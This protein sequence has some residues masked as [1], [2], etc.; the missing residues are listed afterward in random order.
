[1]N[2]DKTVPRSIA[3]KAARLRWDIFCRIVD[4]YGDIGV[5]WRLARQLA[6]E[7][8]LAVRL[9]VD[10]AGIAQRMITGMQPSLERQVMDGVEI[11]R[12][13]D[14]F[15]DE[16]VADVVIEAF[17]CELPRN[18]LVA[19]VK[20]RPIWLN[21]EYLSAEN[22]VEEFHLRPSPQPALPLTKH[23]FFPG[24]TGQTGGLIREQG[25]I[26]QRDAF[27]NSSQAQATFW[28]KLAVVDSAALKVSLFCY[29]D[30]PIT[31]LLQ[32][33]AASSQPVLCL[34][35]DSGILPAIAKYFGA[36]PLKVGDRLSKNN[37][38][39]QPLP[40]LS[41]DDYDCLLWVCDLNFV[42]G[43]DSWVRALWAARPLIWQPYRQQQ[44]THLLKL[45]AF[46]D[47][48]ST[49]LGKGAGSALREAHAT[50]CGHGFAAE[51]WQSV[52]THLPELRVH[53][54]GQTRLLAAHTDLA[55]KLVIFCQNQV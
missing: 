32:S 41:Q 28:N 31:D 27:Q 26:E 40:F 4:N 54:I 50:W 42:R 45:Q 43:E 38:T 24:F 49:G 5:C 33:M 53:A 7:Y 21:L 19:M 29:A 23:F 1:M 16:M 51:N 37:L 11:C 17:G 35:P 12:W 2:Q 10:E 20:T 44:Q 14:P 6:H 30:A 39:V 25:L 13:A 47:F 9:W 8:G 22:W 34:V 18:Y 36:S 48:Y 55:A 15:A 3:R 46:L 52:L